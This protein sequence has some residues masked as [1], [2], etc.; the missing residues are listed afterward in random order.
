VVLSFVC[1]H[2]RLV[3]SFIHWAG[4]VAGRLSFSCSLS[5]RGIATLSHPLSLS[6]FVHRAGGMACCSRLGVQRLGT[7]RLE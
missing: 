6:S 4:D 5:W 2:S 1:W 3:L 7:G